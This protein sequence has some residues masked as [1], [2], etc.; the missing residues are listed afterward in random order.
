MTLLV[1]LLFLIIDPGF[2]LV[3]RYGPPGDG[4]NVGFGRRLGKIFRWEGDTHGD[5]TTCGVKTNLNGQFQ[6]LYYYGEGQACVVKFPNGDMYFRDADHTGN[7]TPYDA[8][9]ADHRAIV[10]QASQMAEAARVIVARYEKDTIGEETA[11]HDM[12]LEVDPYREP[13]VG[14]SGVSSDGEQYRWEGNTKRSKS[15]GFRAKGHGVKTFIGEK[16]KG[17]KHCGEFKEGKPWGNYVEC[18]EDGKFQNNKKK[19]MTRKLTL[20]REN[21]IS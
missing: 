3:Y 8:G 14:T 16:C 4:P 12:W 18:H 20:Y 6:S 15:T 5:Y 2:R 7:E 21:D 10:D 19:E 17:V 9:D 13:N 11:F 1:N